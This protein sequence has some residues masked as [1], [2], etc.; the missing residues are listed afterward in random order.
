MIVNAARRGHAL[1]ELHVPVAERDF[2]M[3]E[4]AVAIEIEDVWESIACQEAGVI[5]HLEMQVRAG[6]M[7][8]IT[9]EAQHLAR[10]YA[11]AGFDAY[12]GLQVSVGRVPAI[13]KIEDYRVP[14]DVL[15]GHFERRVVS[16]H[17]FG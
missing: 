7:T 2:G 5:A 15:Q 3:V 16:G 11:I 17:V 13:A 4:A 8:G 10:L 1:L 9:D 12:A 14:R 6:G